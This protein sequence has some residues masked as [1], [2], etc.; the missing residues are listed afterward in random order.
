[1]CPPPQERCH[2]GSLSDNQPPAKFWS[3]AGLG[4]RRYL[5][6]PA[7]SSWTISNPINL[8]LHRRGQ[9]LLGGNRGER[10]RQHPQSGIRGGKNCSLQKAT[11]IGKLSNGLNGYMQPRVHLSHTQ[12]AGGETRSPKFKR[13]K[14]HNAQNAH[15]RLLL[16]AVG[17]PK[18]QQIRRREREEGDQE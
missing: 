4:A 11:D 9:G 7:E 10:T 1:M 2:Q 5:E 18:T 17:N 15:D 12:P 16:L 6:C 14:V 13:G 8:N 3:D